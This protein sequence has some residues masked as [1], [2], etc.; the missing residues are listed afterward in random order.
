MVKELAIAYF[1]KELINGLRSIANLK[2]PWL[3]IFH[4]ILIWGLYY[5][6]AYVCFF[7]LP[8]TTNLGLS[9]ALF[10]LTLGGI[11]MSAP[12]QGGIGVY[13]LLVSQGLM[14][15]G[16]SQQDGLTFATL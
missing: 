14:L 11:G 12:V 16:L 4:S 1:I 10:V 13:H 5:L 15:Y 3:F 6:S 2:L 7:A 8:S 9:A